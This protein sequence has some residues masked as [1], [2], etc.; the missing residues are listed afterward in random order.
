MQQNDVMVSELVDQAEELRREGRL[1]EALETVERCLEENPGHL[2]ALLLQGR[3]LY[4]GGMVSQALR[5][6][7]LLEEL[8]GRDEALARITE[9]LKGLLQEPEPD[10]DP[11]F[12]TET[13]A[14]LHIKQ[15]YLW[16]A[17]EIYRHLW[18]VSPGDKLWEKILDL[19][20]GL[21]KERFKTK[22]EKVRRLAALDQWL[23]RQRKE[24]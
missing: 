23:A 24:D 15:G 13:M 5:A 8:L 19:R 2:R 18:G 17:M 11:A 6:L 7:D 4:Q 3:V 10:V 20:Q 22:E 21:E 14:E 1:E 16:D 9:G 12:V